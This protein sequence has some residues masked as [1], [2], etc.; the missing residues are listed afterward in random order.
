MLGGFG[1]R[2]VAI[3]SLLA[4]AAL[5]WVAAGLALGKAG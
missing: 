5:L 3:V 1:S 4:G 2:W